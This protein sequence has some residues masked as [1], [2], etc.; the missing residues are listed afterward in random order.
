MLQLF[1]AM[2]FVCTK[3]TFVLT[4]WHFSFKKNALS[5]QWAETAAHRFQQKVSFHS[6]QW[7]KF[8]KEPKNLFSMGNAWALALRSSI[9]HI[10]SWIAVPPVHIEV[11]ELPLQ[12]CP[13]NALPFWPQFG[14]HRYCRHVIC[15]YM[16]IIYTHYTSL[17]IHVSKIIGKTSSAYLFLVLWG[18][19][20]SQASWCLQ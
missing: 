12:G 16:C 14:W 10:W 1:I 7:T 5:K 19:I 4:L 20:Y 18:N 13:R 11:L 8:P 17:Y 2:G 6:F 15:T 3:W 9:I